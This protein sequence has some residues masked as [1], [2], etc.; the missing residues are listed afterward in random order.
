M[1]KTRVQLDV[2]DIVQTQECLK[3]IFDAFDDVEWEYPTFNMTNMVI[4]FY[5]AQSLIDIFVV[6][7]RIADALERK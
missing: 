4:A 7:E 1:K 6:L 3:Q 2:H 5:Q